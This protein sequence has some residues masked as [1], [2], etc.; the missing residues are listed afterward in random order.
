MPSRC[1]L[2]CEEQETETLFISTVAT[3][4]RVKECLKNIMPLLRQ[5]EQLCQGTY[6][7][8]ILYGTDNK[9]RKVQIVP[10]FFVWRERC[11][12]IFREEKKGPRQTATEIGHEYDNWYGG[13]Q[14]QGNK[15]IKHCK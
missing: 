15:E 11:I 14:K 9:V 10:C 4:N 6:N 12:R 2:C 7:N 5:S 13:S 3:C 8:I 1:C